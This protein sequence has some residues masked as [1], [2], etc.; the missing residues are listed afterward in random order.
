MSKRLHVRGGSGGTW[1][2]AVIT[3][4]YTTGLVVASG[5]NDTDGTIDAVEEL[6]VIRIWDMIF[7][8]LGGWFRRFV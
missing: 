4:L 2:V 8:K 5:G 3:W 6:D 1:S 7:G